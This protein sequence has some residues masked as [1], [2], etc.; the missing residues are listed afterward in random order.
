MRRLKPILL[1]A[2]IICLVAASTFFLFPEEAE[3][4]LFSF[5]LPWD[6][7]KETV[8]SIDR[9]LDKPAG[10][11][12]HVYVGTDGHLYVGT[13]RIRFLGVNICGGAAFPKKEEAEK[14]A[15]RLV[16]FGVNIVRF[17]HMDASWESFNIFNKTSG[18]TRYLNEEALDKLSYFVAK[19]KENGVYV[20]LN[21]LVSRRLTSADGLPTEINEVEWKD[22]QVLGFFIEDILELQKEY[23]KHL[24]M[25]R[26]PYTGLT[27]AEDPAVA[28]VEIVNEQGLIHGWLGGVIDGL[29]DLFKEKL[30]EKWNRYLAQIYGSTENLTETWKGGPAPP[31]VEMLANGYF[32]AG[33]DGWVTETHG[34]AEASYEIVEDPDGT[35]VLEV[36]VSKPGE[37][38]WH[39]QFN[40]PRLSV[41][42]EQ[43]YFVRFR[44]RANKKVTV[45][46]ALRQAHEP[47]TGLSNIVPVEL[48]PEWKNYE[49]ALIAS[50]SDNNARLDI[51][52]MGTSEATYQ[53]SC[54][55][56]KQFEG[57][58]L[59][60]E[61]SLENSTVS[62]FT[63]GNFGVRTIRAREDWVKFLWSL[64]E[65]YFTE[66]RDYLKKDLEVKAPVIGTIVGCSTPNIMAQMDVID[67]HA[68]W[69]HPS[70]PGRPWDPSNW[71]VVN[72]PMVNHL[73]EGTIPQLALKRVYGKPHLVTEYNHPTPN[74]YDA[75]TV[76]TLASYAALQDW[77]GIFMFDY[78]SR[79]NWDA[80]QLR[81]YF[82]I[83]QHPAKM[84]T[85]IPAYMIFVKGAVEPAENL[86]A[87]SLSKQKEIELIAKGRVYA[88]NLVD[89]THLGI[90]A[91]APLIHRTALVVEGGL[92]PD[93]TLIPQDLNISGSV[94]R[95][96]TGN[97]VWDISDREKG[98]LLVNTSSSIAVVGFGEGKKFDFG[99]VIIE[100][101][102][103]LLD[104]WSIITL[105][106]MEGQ[107]FKDFARLLLIAAGYTTN[108]GMKVREYG[109]GN[110]L[111]EGSTSLTKIRR[112][113]GEITCANSWG[114]APTL[115]E[116]VPVTVKVQT[117]K[118]IEVWALNS[119]G[120]RTTQVQVH[121]QAGF[122]IFTLGSEYHTIW[123]EIVVKSE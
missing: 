102:K 9:W 120:E 30:Q 77:D 90:Q 57:Y 4:Q 50:S 62:I 123:Y 73:D 28:F 54:F 76:V 47:W 55:S 6:D 95:S 2:G 16:K 68:Y 3:S 85:L 59:M 53:F 13:E 14:I 87:V 118:N 111:A 33:L 119:I 71:Y 66:M 112:Y 81:G 34:K 11:Q 113:N 86:I 8:V 116:G 52:N 93:R 48:G 70:F 42:A 83:D 94:Y 10:R 60:E 17:H 43:T 36:K 108:T 89:G 121:S 23:A 25:H 117:S 105:N 91:A 1:M 58:A 49:L 64:E 104:G 74:M 27:F 114:E 22:Q 97:V 122:K 106:V 99:R 92:E 39:V 38:G 5:Y 65:G 35:K 101:G 29:P 31:Q 84:A 7:S 82:D 69:H 79:N 109:S 63:L 56:M 40:Y 51:S 98:V 12:G 61:E 115:V 78:G 96:D 19:L 103:T 41:K 44:A 88:W 21:L 67:T 24:L 80:E 75:E 18:N 46:I 100:P 20:D 72:E 15:A 107:N 26:N 32:E 110:L 45:N 37:S